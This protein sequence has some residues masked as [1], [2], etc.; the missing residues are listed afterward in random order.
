MI[1]DL[2]GQDTGMIFKKEKK[3]KTFKKNLSS[4]GI[5]N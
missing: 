2:A 5:T 3:R 1:E 4:S